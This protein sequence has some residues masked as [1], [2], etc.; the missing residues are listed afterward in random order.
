[1]QRGPSAKSL[2]IYKSLS[3][4]VASVRQL[5]SRQLRTVR[6]PTLKG[7]DMLAGR[8][9]LCASKDPFTK[10]CLGCCASG[11]YVCGVRLRP[12]RRVRAFRR[13][14]TR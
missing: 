6:S 14:R 8:K 1:M 9:A 12:L 11:S 3:P 10:R 2:E 4:L 5:K 13:G 7:A